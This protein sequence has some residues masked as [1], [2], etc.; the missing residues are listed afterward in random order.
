MIGL[1]SLF[2]CFILELSCHPTSCNT[3]SMALFLEMSS[4]TQKHKNDPKRYS[5]AVILPQKYTKNRKQGG[6]HVHK[7][8]KLGAEYK[9]KKKN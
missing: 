1:F 4:A 9:H 2:C 7:A 6:E 8:Y 5:K 3:I